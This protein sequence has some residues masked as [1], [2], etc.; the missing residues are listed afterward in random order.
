MPLPPPPP[1]HM[2]PAPHHPPLPPTPKSPPPS[3]PRP[4]VPPGFGNS[5]SDRGAGAGNV[6]SRPRPPP[7]PPAA[8][9][10]AVEPL[11]TAAI[12]GLSTTALLLLICPFLAFYACYRVYRRRRKICGKG[13]ASSSTSSSTPAIEVEIVDSNSHI[14]V[15][16]ALPQLSLELPVAAEGQQSAC[17][18][19]A[20]RDGPSS[21]YTM[22][23]GA[24]TSQ[25]TQ[26]PAKPLKEYTRVLQQR[27]DLALTMSM[28]QVVDEACERLG[29]VPIM[30][31]VAEG[32]V[33]SYV[34][35][36][37]RC[38]DQL[39]QLERG[40]SLNLPLEQSAS[41]PDEIRDGPPSDSE[42]AV[43]STSQGL[44]PAS[45]PAKPLGKY[46]RVLQ[47]RL[48]LAPTMSMVQVVDQACETLS[49]VPTTD[50]VGGEGEVIDYVKTARRCVDQLEY[51]SAT[52]SA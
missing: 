37:R 47:Q 4:T 38:V 18:S 10:Q 42:E 39:E 51:W 49:V 6:L 24:S 48:K 41:S 22:E 23:S 5:N 2:P 15:P 45:S 34:K 52:R 30:D 16:A 25:G 35:T 29:I 46:T 50:S 20:T 33:V 27:L 28:V 11:S 17:L 12:A 40:S 21:T 3:P 13:S 14:T 44:I 1:P 7:L 19:E 36:A 26:S 32:K 43:T 31:R 9:L 8:P